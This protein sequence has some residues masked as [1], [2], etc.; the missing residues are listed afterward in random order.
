[1][2]RVKKRI[3][4]SPPPYTLAGPPYDQLP[5][6]PPSPH[7]QP[8]PKRH[9]SLSGLRRVLSRFNICSNPT[10][11]SRSSTIHDIPFTHSLQ[12]TTSLHPF[13]SLRRWTSRADHIRPTSRHETYVMVPAD[14]ISAHSTQNMEDVSDTGHSNVTPLPT[15]TDL[16][17]AEIEW[18]SQSL[19]LGEEARRSL[20]GAR[21]LKIFDPFTGF[22]R[23]SFNS[24]DQDRAHWA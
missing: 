2:K 5:S 1:M 22:V 24:V 11:I 6:P 10:S 16:E 8:P 17:E 3:I 14:P 18:R 23:R 4:P 13:K 9:N 20:E 15:Y 19:G 12:S 7:S 21:C